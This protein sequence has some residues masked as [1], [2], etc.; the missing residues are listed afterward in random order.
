VSRMILG[1]AREIG[2]LILDPLL[3]DEYGYLIPLIFS[4]D[5][6]GGNFLLDRWVCGAV[7]KILQ[8]H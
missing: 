8:N 5:R 4:N 6:A 1:R 3:T 2:C 7:R